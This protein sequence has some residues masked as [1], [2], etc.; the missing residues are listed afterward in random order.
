MCVCAVF[1]K[2]IRRVNDVGQVSMLFYVG[3]VLAGSSIAVVLD[4]LGDC[5]SPVN[6]SGMYLFHV[7]F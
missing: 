1:G 5:Q 4:Q 6:L 2:H 7:C 3:L